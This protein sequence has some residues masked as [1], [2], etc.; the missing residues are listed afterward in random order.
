MPPTDFKVTLQIPAANLSPNRRRGAFVSEPAVLVKRKGRAP[1]L[2]SVEKLEMKLIDVRDLLLQ[3]KQ[4]LAEG[5]QRRQ[6]FTD[7][8]HEMHENYLL[9]GVANVFL[10]VLFHANITLDYQVPIISQ[11]GEV[12]GRLH[13]ELGVVAGSLGRGERVADAAVDDNSDAS[14][15]DSDDTHSG[16]GD[17]VRVR[18]AIKAARGLPLS[19]ANY[20]FCQYSLFGLE[21][22]VV[23]PW[24][25]SAGGPPN[26]VES[27][28]ACFRF[29]HAREFT[30]PVTEEL[31]EHC[32]EGAL[33]IEIWGHR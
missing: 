19:L 33:S 29:E 2:W 11:Q 25:D 21:P 7:P 8:F 32:A 20:V 6:S 30:L 18:V 14:A 16:G 31:L 5:S 9:I 12:A 15:S 28:T 26:S 17:H 4:A 23:A 3:R 1:Q 10:E 24:N 27:S 13:V 22:V